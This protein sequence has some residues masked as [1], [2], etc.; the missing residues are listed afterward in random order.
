MVNRWRNSGNR[1]RLHIF[2]FQNHCR[3]WLQPWNQKMLTPWEKSYDQTRQHIKKQ[4]CYFANKGSSNQGYA[5]SSSHIWMLELDNKE[6]WVLKNWCF[7]TMV[8]EKI[9]ESPLDWKEIQPVHPKGNQPWIFIGRTDVGE[10]SNT[11]ATWCKE[12]TQLKRSWWWE[13]LKGGRR[14]G[15]Q[16]IRCL[17]DITDSIDMNLSKVQELV[18]DREAC[19]SP[20]GHK[21]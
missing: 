4:R 3:W 2:G 9:L 19:F 13:I 20:W 8:L 17:D 18:M 1:G 12:L 15:R 21:D 14:L 7:W 11:L 10:N 16:R 5:F 6:N